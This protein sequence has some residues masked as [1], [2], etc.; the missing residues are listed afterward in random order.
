MTEKVDF[1]FLYFFEMR[2]VGKEI[3]YFATSFGREIMYFATRV[4]IK[5]IV[6]F[7]TLGYVKEIV[8]FATRVY[9]GKVSRTDS[10]HDPNMPNT[11]PRISHQYPD[12]CPAHVGHMSET[13][14]KHM[15]PRR[16]RPPWGYR[17]GVYREEG[18]PQDPLKLQKS[19]FW[20]SYS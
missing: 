8:Y 12:G 15:A 6:Y 20:L 14:L 11:C 5:E 10:E 13:C 16:N 17:G 4:Y 7:A 2:T 1:V 3:V 18:Y 9:C 19:L